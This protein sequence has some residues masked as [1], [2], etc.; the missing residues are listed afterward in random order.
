MKHMLFLLVA[1]LSFSTLAAT[2]IIPVLNE[3]N[4]GIF[5]STYT[6]KIGNSGLDIAIDCA[7]GAGIRD[8]FEDCRAF[9]CE[10][11]AVRS[12]QT[13][14]F[15]GGSGHAVAIAQVQVIIDGKSCKK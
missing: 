15:A 6:C 9:P 4:E 11:C 13:L 7:T 1:I 10:I 12:F 3:V 5:K 8:S 14:D 2:E